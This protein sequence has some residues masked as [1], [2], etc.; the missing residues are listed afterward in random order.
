MQRVLVTI[1]GVWV[2]VSGFFTGLPNMIMPWDKPGQVVEDTAAVLELYQDIAQKNG[3]TQLRDRFK[4]ADAV[5][6]GDAEGMRH[7]FWDAIDS[8]FGVE[9]DCSILMGLPGSPAKLRAADIA[10]AKAEYYHNGKT[11]EITII[12]RGE[13]IE[14]LALFFGDFLNDPSGWF[15]EVPK[16]NWTL[17]GR[18]PEIVVRADVASGKIKKARLYAEFDFAAD[19]TEGIKQAEFGYCAARP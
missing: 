10:S 6:A 7:P 8:F 4:I 11:V 17:E 16:D 19:V 13:T 9:F 15:V 18:N 14:S 3:D 12:P 2:M 5:Y 1:M